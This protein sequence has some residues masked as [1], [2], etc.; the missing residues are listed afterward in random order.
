MA[1]LFDFELDQATMTTLNCT[2]CHEHIALLL[3]LEFF[4]LLNNLGDGWHLVPLS[5]VRTPVK[6]SGITAVHFHFHLPLLRPWLR[7]YEEKW[8]RHPSG[9]SG[10]GPDLDKGMEADGIR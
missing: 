8:L 3:L 2:V 1:A 10:S 7:P 9:I 6:F 5:E 4:Q